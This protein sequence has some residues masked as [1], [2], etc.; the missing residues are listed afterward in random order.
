[1]CTKRAENGRDSPVTLVGLNR[2]ICSHSPGLA[3]RGQKA[4]LPG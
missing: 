3:V 2:S 1:M 4:E